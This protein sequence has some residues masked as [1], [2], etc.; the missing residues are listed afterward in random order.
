MDDLE[1]SRY[2]FVFGDRVNFGSLFKLDIGRKV[3]LFDKFRSKMK[4]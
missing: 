4:L 1:L 3:V 2:I